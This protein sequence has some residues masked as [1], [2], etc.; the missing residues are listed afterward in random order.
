MADFFRISVHFLGG[1]FHGRGDGDEPEWP[2]SPL[3]LF[4]AMTNA[5]ARLDGKDIGMESAL[6]LR[7]LEALK[8]PP[9]IVA[10]RATPATGYKLYVPDN[11]SDLVAKK[12]SAGTYFDNKNHPIDISDYRTEKAVRPLRLSGDSTVHYL[13]PLCPDSVSEFAQHRETLITLARSVVCLGWGVDLVVADAALEAKIDTHLTPSSERW[14]AVETSGGS[15]L[16]VPI[17]GTLNALKERH[18]AF[19]GRLQ[20]T[21]DGGQYFRPVPPLT[22][23]GLV[24]Y[25]RETDLASPPFAVFALREPDDS[26]FAAFDP[27]WRRLHLSGM[28]RHTASHPDFAAALGWNDGKVNRFVLGHDTKSPNSPNPSRD[29]DRLIFIPLPSIE[30]RGKDRGRS[31]GSVRRVLVTIQGHCS[32]PEFD[33]IVRSMEGREL[34]D[35][36]NS[37]PI[38]FLRQQTAKDSAIADY[39]GE[40]AIWTTVTP[41][42]LPGHDDPRKLRR[43]LNDE[44][45]PCSVQEKEQIIRKLDARTDH[46]LRKAFL[47]AGIPK[48]LVENADLQWRATG[49]LPGADLASR[50]SVPDQCRRFRRL[51]VRVFWREP[52]TRDEYV[53]LRLTGPFCIGSG[54]FSG[55]GLFAPIHD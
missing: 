35:E 39:L 8:T 15:M 19:L 28:L 1:E 46:L 53:P 11:V 26:R 14:L 33:R 27:K 42:V 7:W 23:F 52:Q 6:A 21:D 30:W 43:R 51:H 38:A 50:Y 36:K 10:S 45:K 4:Q 9:E 44:S 12:W 17:A 47:N 49:F 34:I 32:S 20:T 48:P 31:I 13:W 24:T 54:R 5:A 2:P 18:K 16:R 37:R 55:L 25:R 40:S 22:N 41:V 3:R 29:A